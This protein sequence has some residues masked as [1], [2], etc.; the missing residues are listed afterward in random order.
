MKYLITK[1]ELEFISN[2]KNF[3]E[4]EDIIMKITNKLAVPIEWAQNKLSD[5]M[6]KNLHKVIHKSLTGA[7]KVALKTMDNEQ[8]KN[9]W[10]D[11]LTN[12]AKNK[13]FHNTAIGLSGA[14]GGF[15]G[16]VAVLAELPISTTI[17]MRSIAS[18]AREMGMD[19]KDPSFPFECLYIFSLGSKKPNDDN[20][21]TGY[22]ASRIALN[23]AIA[24]STEFV[25]NSS[26]KMVLES[27]EKGTAPAVISFI[28]RIAGYFEVVVTEKMI[29]EAIPIVGS[30]G[31][32]TINILFNNYYAE[33]AKYHFGLKALER[34]YG[35]EAVQSQYE[36][37][38]NQSTKA[39]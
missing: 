12:S 21:D 31:G 2:A 9:S 39:A 34:K 30:F 38:M 23:A 20:M 13:F 11:S 33:A 17:M 15:F 29:F 16:E 26:A 5:D 32:A 25:A 10:S 4:S 22:Y 27:L 28:G 1:E 14:I 18:T 24:K 7:M 3:F 36:L 35:L 8:I 19:Q 6:K 37:L